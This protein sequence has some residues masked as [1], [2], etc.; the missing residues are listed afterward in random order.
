MMTMTTTMMT[1]TMMIVTTTMTA[2]RTQTARRLSLQSALP[3]LQPEISLQ[4]VLK[5][6]RL[7]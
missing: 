2:T 7:E 1:A 3:R 5:D 4:L 6:P